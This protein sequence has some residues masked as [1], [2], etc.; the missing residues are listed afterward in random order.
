M[1]CSETQPELVAYHF[2]ETSPETR[3]EIE[4]HLLGCRS[5]LSQFLDLKRAIE[6]A[7]LDAG[8]SEQ[9][10]LA[11]RRAVAREVVPPAP[12]AWS[13]WE[14]PA[15]LVFAGATVAV[16]LLIVQVVSTGR[17]SMPHSLDEA[18]ALVHPATAR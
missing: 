18:P 14:R 6:T 16:A 5:C 2:G 4:D 7:D 15:A 13:W 3:S 11:L 9:A 12:R 1:S 17:G 10:R 8:P